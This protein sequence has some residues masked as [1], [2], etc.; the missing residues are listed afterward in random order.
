MALKYSV[1]N[2]IAEHDEDAADY[3]ESTQRRV[4]YRFYISV[5]GHLNHEYDWNKNKMNFLLM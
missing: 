1:E 2:I 3:I 5:K 4:Y